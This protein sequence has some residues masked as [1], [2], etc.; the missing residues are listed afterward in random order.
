MGECT[1]HSAD[2]HNENA[3]STPTSDSGKEGEDLHAN[4]SGFTKLTNCTNS[5]TEISNLP[6]NKH[7]T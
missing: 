2:S 3:Q 6:H 7:I 5:V 4:V 1:M